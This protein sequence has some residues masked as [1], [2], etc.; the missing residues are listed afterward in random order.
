MIK[1]TTKLTV[2]AALLAVTALS[3]QAE[4]V[5]IT[6][7]SGGTGDSANYRVDN[8]EI[9]ADI[10]EREAEIRGDDL[11]INIEKQV[12]S[13]WDD[14]RQAVTLAGEAGNGP[15]II[16][17]GHDDIPTW[18]QAGL[19]RPVE[20]YVY[21]DTYPLNQ[22]Y[23]NL[24]DVVTFNDQV[25]GVPQDAEA[26]V[27]FW[28]IPG[29]KAI[30]WSDAEID[31]LPEKVRSGE[32]TLYDMLDAVKKMQ[33]EGVIE[34]GKGF[35]PRP[36]NGLDYWQFY[37][38]FGGELSDPETGKL[39][40]DTEAMQQAYQFFADAVSQGVVPATYLGLPWDTWHGSV[41][42]N[43]YGAW[44]GGSWH[45]AQWTRQS[46]MDDFFGN[47]QY[48][49]IPAGDEDGRA[50]SITHPLAYLLSSEGS[51]A[52]AEISAQ[53]IAIATNPELNALHAVKSGHLAI[54]KD[55]V[56]VPLYAE[57]RWLSEASAFL[58]D[59]NAVPNNVNAGLYQNAMFAG[60]EA[61]WTGALTPEEAVNELKAKVQADLGDAII[62]R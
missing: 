19:L 33:D 55:E 15:N 41:A 18:S 36:S 23:S 7:W 45:Y 61:A 28:S 46:G 8:I 43:Q 57:D 16:V 13:G 25:W 4:D 22:V 47:V 30:G 37:Q 1:L 48:T 53:L 12:W 26:R 52:D 27:M 38:S 31:A 62:I 14:F 34:E 60:L 3:A 59:A 29:L 9:A 2:A 6:V 21:L 17:A 54:G 40:L 32:F 56:N 11:N 20:D 50:N 39:V 44:H 24:W 5:N 58:P 42:D 49:L 35:A 51:E 10:L